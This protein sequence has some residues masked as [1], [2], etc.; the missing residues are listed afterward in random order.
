MLR[1][2]NVKVAKS[3]TPQKETRH[4][5]IKTFPSTPA[6][7]FRRLGLPLEPSR[8]QLSAPRRV[9]TK[10]PSATVGAVVKGGVVFRGRGW[11]A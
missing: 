8:P 7:A 3:R 6:M 9:A 5:P 10:E 1:L 11:K 2:Q 4:L